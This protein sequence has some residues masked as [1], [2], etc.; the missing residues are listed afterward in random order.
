MKFRRLLMMLLL[1]PVMMGFGIPEGDPP[2]APAAGDPPASDPPPAADPPAGDPPAGDPSPTKTP[3]EIA[4]EEAAAA[5]KVAAEKL[6]GAPE[7]YTAFTMP[8]GVPAPEGFDAALGGIAKDFNLSQDG[9]QALLNRLQTDIQPLM[10]ADREKAWQGVRD[11]WK[12]QLKA[13]PELGGAKYDQT[14]AVAT[15]AINT[16]MTDDIKSVL[17]EYGL[18]DHPGMVRLMYKIGTT[19]REDTFVPPAGGSTPESRL[20]ALYPTMQ[21]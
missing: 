18:G 17:A 19:I 21:K 2:P 11:G 3:E 12:E 7:A 16:F 1:C 15:R 4:A 8:E 6:V 13:D 9:A 10:Q 14:V 5:K 20:A